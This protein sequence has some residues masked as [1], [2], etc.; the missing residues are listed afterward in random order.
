[1]KM[2]L[3]MNFSINVSNMSSNYIDYCELNQMAMLN[4][5]EKMPVNILILIGLSFLALLIYVFITPMLKEKIREIVKHSLVMFATGTLLF[6]IIFLVAITFNITQATWELAS[7]IITWVAI[8]I[9]V[10]AMFIKRKKI[11]EF[12][13]NLNKARTD[14]NG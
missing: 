3:P 11:K 10:T 2:V 6:G 7:N 9:I 13:N 14:N 4:Q 5:V 8:I 1:M 12:I